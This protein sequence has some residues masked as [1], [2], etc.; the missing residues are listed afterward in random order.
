MKQN[1]IDGHK[2]LTNKLYNYQLFS[3]K[4]LRQISYGH[5]GHKRLLYFQFA[6][7]ETSLVM[8]YSQETKKSTFFQIQF[9][10]FLSRLVKTLVNRSLIKPWKLSSKKIIFQSI[11]EIFFHSQPSKLDARADLEFREMILVGWVNK[12]MS[13]SQCRWQTP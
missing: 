7:T 9:C 3:K 2:V 6:T 11:R 10:P 1:K 12:K 8:A 13:D 5:L 4:C